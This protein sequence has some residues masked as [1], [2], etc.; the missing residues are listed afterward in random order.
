MGRENAPAPYP[1]RQ[2]APFRQQVEAV[3]VDDHRAAVALQQPVQQRP[4]VAADAQTAAHQQALGLFSLG[5]HGP[6]ALPADDALS[7]FRPVQRQ[8]KGLRQRRAGGG[9]H[10]G[11]GAQLHQPRPGPQ[12]R[13]PRQQGRSR[14]GGAAAHQRRPAKGPLGRGLLPPGQQRPGGLFI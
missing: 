4:A 14:H 6:G 12:G 9:D 2:S 5:Q 3:G 10:L 7:P 11:H 13:Q 8:Q 1:G